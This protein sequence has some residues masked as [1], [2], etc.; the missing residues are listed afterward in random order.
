[1]KEEKQTSESL[2]FTD[3]FTFCENVIH[4]FQKNTQ[5]SHANR[6]QNSLPD[7]CG[8]RFFSILYVCT[9]FLNLEVRIRESDEF[10]EFD[11]LAPL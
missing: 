5:R 7:L 10:K 8:S 9:L 11:L 3:F 2:L 1:M 4:R 6:G